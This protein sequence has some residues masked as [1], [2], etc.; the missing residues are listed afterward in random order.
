M[1]NPW[2]ARD[3]VLL[4]ALDRLPRSP[5]AGPVW[6]AIVDGRDP[7]VG[8]PSNGRW[9]PGVFDVIYYSLTSNGALAEL[10]FHLSRQPVFPSKSFS[11]HQVR[12]QARATLRFANLSELEGLGVEVGQYSEILYRRTQEI[13]DA[14]HFLGFDGII[15]PSARA[16]AH[17]LVVFVDRLEL[18]D[19]ELESS[20]AIDWSG[21]RGG[22]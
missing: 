21:W 4:D 10:Y 5:F 20:S 15:A 9:D 22:S 2:T 17:N 7:L 18:D 8:F 12:V 13:G 3:H 11:L 14:A 19:L 1:K 6:R 16:D